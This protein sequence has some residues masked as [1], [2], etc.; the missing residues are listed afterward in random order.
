MTPARPEPLVARDGRPAREL[1]ALDPAVVHLNHG[2]YGG[3]PL[4]TVTERA[5]LLAEVDRNP[6]RWHLGIVPRL[7]AACGSIAG[8]LGVAADELAFVPSASAGTTA[9]LRGLATGGEVVLTDHA[10][11]A[12]A[13]SVQGFCERRG[14]RPRVVAVP[15]EAEAPETAERILDAVGSRTSL[16]VLDQISSAT[17]RGFPIDTIA[18]AAGVPVLV[19]AAHAPGML[20]QPAAVRADAWVGN[21]HKF[22]CGVRAAAVIVLRGDATRRVWPP[23]DSWGHDAPFPARFDEQGTLDVTAYLATAA[24]IVRLE[25]ELGWERIREHQRALLGYG[26]EVIADAIAAATGE[27]PRVRVGMPAP[28]MAL[29]RLPGRLGA[30]PAEASALRERISAELGIETQLPS[31]DGVGYLRLSAHAYSTA[32]DFERVA[33]DMVPLLVGLLGRSG[34]ANEF[35]IVD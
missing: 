30:T 29:L 4:A 25:R 34:V 10:Y 12:L 23:V 2:S 9:A 32:E 13:R 11:G 28:A 3:A 8:F 35:G 19:D 20:A 27:D 17:A 22:A 5:R 14:L 7:R 18:A 1:W 24:G 16:V 33:E 21:L 15:L 26:R 6:L 31:R